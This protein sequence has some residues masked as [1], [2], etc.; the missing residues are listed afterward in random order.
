[1]YEVPVI[2]DLLTLASVLCCNI[3]SVSNL[4]E[5]YILSKQRIQSILKCLEWINLLLI[6][7]DPYYY[8]SFNRLHLLCSG[9]IEINPGPTNLKIGE[10]GVK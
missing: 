9:D 2:Y 6:C 4:I 5:K 10:T 7:S 8:S 1:M 3:A